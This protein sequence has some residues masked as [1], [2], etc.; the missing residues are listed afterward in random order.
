MEASAKEMA[1]ISWVTGYVTGAAV[2]LAKRGMVL[3][4]TTGRDILA[5]I[6]EALVSRTRAPPW[7]LPPLRSCVNCLVA[8]IPQSSSASDF[9]SIRRPIFA[10]MKAYC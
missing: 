5:S 7:K 8:K 1:V 3:R 2:I 10:Y 4:D 9:S 6:H